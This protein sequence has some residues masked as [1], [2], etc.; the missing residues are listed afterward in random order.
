MQT[1]SAFELTMA[2]SPGSF[3][4]LR[5]GRRVMPKAT[6]FAVFRLG[7]SPKKASSVGLAPGQPPSI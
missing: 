2:A 5:P 4:A 7:G 3:C 1:A 6:S